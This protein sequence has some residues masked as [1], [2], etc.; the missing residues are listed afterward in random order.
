IQLDR[1]G[2]HKLVAVVSQPARPVGRKG[3]LTDPPLAQFAK[4][5]NLLVLQPERAS[6]PDFLAQL[7]ALKPDIVITAAYGQILTDDFLKIP[8]RATINLHP[9]L[10]PAY[11]GAT[12]VPQALLEGRSET[13]ITILFTVKK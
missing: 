9:S 1:A 3:I 6:D 10:L 8:S 4:N 7:T 2:K 12:P 11:R 5:Q 13:G